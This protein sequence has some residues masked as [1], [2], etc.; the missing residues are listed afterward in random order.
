LIIV[1]EIKNPDASHFNL[2]SDACIT[3][4]LFRGGDDIRVTPILNELI[5]VLQ[6]PLLGRPS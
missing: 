1:V 3:L 4:V 6:G 5:N 2:I